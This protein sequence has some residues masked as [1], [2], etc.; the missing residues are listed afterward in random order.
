[1]QDYGC[2]I[3]DNS[4]SGNRL[5]LER[6]EAAWRELGLTHDALASVPWREW[7]FV[8]AAYDPGSG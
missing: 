2:L 5:K 4:G 6:D 8:A 1:L 3:G 7:E